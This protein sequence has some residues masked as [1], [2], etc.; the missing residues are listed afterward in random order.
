MKTRILFLTL[1]TSISI[2]LITSGLAFAEPITGCIKRFTGIIYNVQI[3]T[4]PT[5]PC[6]FGA[7]RITWNTEGPQG[8]QGPPGENGQD[9]EDGADGQDGTVIHQVQLEDTNSAACEAAPF[10]MLPNP[11]T[12]G[13]CPN[14]SDIPEPTERRTF[15]IPDPM[16]IDGSV[17]IATVGDIS[18]VPSPTNP[19]PNCVVRFINPNL[20]PTSGGFNFNCDNAILDG[21]P[22]NYVIINP[23]VP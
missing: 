3:G 5:R 8:E 21:V 13:W 12:Y 16:I 15:I 19:F 14:G 4:E 10:P 7:E 6:R 2:C 17:I 9:G 23:P 1:L 11:D 18:A 20:T 22:L